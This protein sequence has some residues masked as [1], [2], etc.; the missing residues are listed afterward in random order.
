MQLTLYTDY[1]LRV[2]I[3]LATK[4]DDLSTIDEISN[5]FNISKN[6]LT[7]VVHKLGEKGVIK[8]IRGKGGGICL[9]H[10]P[11]D[12]NLGK[13]IKE[14]ESNFELVECF[15]PEKNTCMLSPYCSLKGILYEAR[16]A[17][18]KVLENKTLADI[19]VNKNIFL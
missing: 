8:T 9:A 3:Y 13:I 6:H 1:S 2:L 5:K 10:S 19:A 7:R 15:N 18:F 4:K 16:Q 17:F 11:K 14:M 12:I